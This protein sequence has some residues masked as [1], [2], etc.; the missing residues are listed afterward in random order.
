MEDLQPP[1]QTPENP[2]TFVREESPQEKVSGMFSSSKYLFSGLALLLLVVGVAGSVYLSG[3]NSDNRQHAASSSPCTV[4]TQQ[5]SCASSPDGPVSKTNETYI[6]DKCINGTAVSYSCFDTNVGQYYTQTDYCTAAP[7]GPITATGHVFLVRKIG[8]TFSCVADCTLSPSTPHCPTI[9]VA[10]PTPTPSICDTPISC[11][12]PRPG[13]QYENQTSCTCGNLV[14]LTITP[15]PTPL[16]DHAYINLQISLPGIAATTSA[17]NTNPLHPTRLVTLSLLQPNTS[18]SSAVS[19]KGNIFFN[20]VSGL[21]EGGIS[22]GPLIPGNYLA[23]IFLDQYLQYLPE[24]IITIASSSAGYLIS[25]TPLKTVQL[26]SGDLN[27]DNVIDL[28][29]YNIL[30]GCFGKDIT[31][32]PS[33]READLDDNGVVDGIDYNIFLRSLAHIYGQ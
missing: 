33:C 1:V 20:T 28:L 25:T 31:N 30:L 8:S 16:P 18:S 22:I 23:K 26:V 9:P 12:Q 15:T 4:Y 3:Q 14:C 11:P 6:I 5:N 29:D 10:T 17:G 32:N 21:F 13:C 27:N 19:Q 24:N 7:L 2:T